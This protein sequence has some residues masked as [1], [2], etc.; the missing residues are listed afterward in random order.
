MTTTKTPFPALLSGRMPSVMPPSRHCAP[1]RSAK[2]NLLCSP[3]PSQSR[4]AYR[5][6][7]ISISTLPCPPTR[8][9]RFAT[10][11]TVPTRLPTAP[12]RLPSAGLVISVSAC[13]LTQQTIRAARSSKSAPPPL[14]RTALARMWF[15]SSM[16][17]QIRS[18]TRPI[19]RSTAAFPQLLT[20]LLQ[21]L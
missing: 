10:H 3:R 11:S 5:M 17:L 4:P 9:P 18:A 6:L 2:A 14:T 12:K 13:P 19:P 7:L 21:S 15:G 8:I 20:A 1:R 16:C